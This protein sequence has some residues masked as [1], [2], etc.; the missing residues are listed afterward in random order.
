MVFKAGEGAGKSGSFFFFTHDDRFIIKTMRQGEVNIFLKF[1]PSY[2]DHFSKNPQSLLA[3]I[4]GVY[5]V[6]REGIG[7]VQIMLMENTL[8]FK[9]KQNI[10]SIYDL[11]GSTYQRISDQGVL[12]D[13]NF[14]KAL[15]TTV[16]QDYSLQLS[17]QLQRDVAFLEK[18]GLIDYSL[19]LGVESNQKP[20]A[21]NQSNRVYADPSFD[22]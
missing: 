6:H 15:G 16:L 10:K 8:Q 2:I 18:M 14:M 22:E 3:K 21:I 7:R 20:I 11:K 4:F 12:K 1:L 9:N 13:L 5:S 17:R 19:L